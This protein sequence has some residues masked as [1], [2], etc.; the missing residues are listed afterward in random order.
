[1][2][3]SE[4]Y[5]ISAAATDALDSALSALQ[6]LLSRKKQERDERAA[7]FK[8]II[9]IMESELEGVDAEIE[10]MEK[11]I[12]GEAKGSPGKPLDPDAETDLSAEARRT[13]ARAQ[14]AQGEAE[15]ELEA[16]P[17]PRSSERSEAA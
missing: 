9:T 4:A 8:S 10:A 17:V 2:N 11:I 7:G 12:F 5:K 1:M 16:A 13:W 6:L 3:L 15:T 14:G